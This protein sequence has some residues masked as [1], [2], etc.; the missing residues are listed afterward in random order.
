MSILIQKHLSFLDYDFINIGIMITA[1]SII[2]SCKQEN[3][4]WVTSIVK[5]TEFQS[6]VTLEV[7]ASLKKKTKTTMTT[8]VVHSFENNTIR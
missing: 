2:K 6:K 4:S 7:G 1:Y 8:C 3:F 5:L